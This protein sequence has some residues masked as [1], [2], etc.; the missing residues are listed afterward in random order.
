MYYSIVT[1]EKREKVLAAFDFLSVQDHQLGSFNSSGILIGSFYCPSYSC[2]D[3]KFIFDSLKMRYLIS[4]LNHNIFNFNFSG[5]D[6]DFNR[7]LFP[8]HY[9]LISDQELLD[10]ENDADLM[11][12]FLEREMYE[13]CAKLKNKLKQ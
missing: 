8:N 1:F 11:N 5:I 4:E 13:A 12:F 10:M 7:E 9:L 3:I 2:K 6:K